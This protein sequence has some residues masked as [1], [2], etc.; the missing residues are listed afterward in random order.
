MEF[1]PCKADPDVWLKDCD[2]HYE[3]I[4]VYV[5]DIMMMGKAPATFFKDLTEKY[6]Y[7]LKGAENLVT[8]MVVISLM[9]RMARLHGELV[10]ISAR[11]SAT[12][13]SCLV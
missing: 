5:D 3:Y 12:M 1:F 13:S 11:C 6:K 7:N 9:T 4:C 8:I 10:C 2:T